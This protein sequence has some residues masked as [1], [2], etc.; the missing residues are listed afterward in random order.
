MEYSE[1]VVDRSVGPE[2]V[3]TDL[4]TPV[5][6]LDS[7]SCR[8]TGHRSHIRVEVVNDRDTR[9]FRPFVILDGWSKRTF[10]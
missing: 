7:L 8:D 10:F 3:H 2:S 4:S 5:C 6:V 1:W 9:I